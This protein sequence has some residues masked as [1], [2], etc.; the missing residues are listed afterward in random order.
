[1]DRCLAHAAAPCC[2]LR[3]DWARSA[4]HN[5]AIL[6]HSA[7]LHFGLSTD[8]QVAI[9]QLQLLPPLHA[10]PDLP[11]LALRV[12]GH[13]RGAHGIRDL[14]LEAR[15]RRPIGN[16]Y[17]KP[18][19]GGVRYNSFPRRLEL[20]VRMKVHCDSSSVRLPVEKS[21]PPWDFGGATLNP[22]GGNQRIP[23]SL[24]RANNCDARTRTSTIAASLRH[25]TGIAG[26]AGA[27]V[28]RWSFQVQE[29]ETSPPSEADGRLL[30]RIAER[31][32]R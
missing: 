28:M 12:L 23:A 9:A 24:S 27:S 3:C 14:N 21:N 10:K 30:K 18:G 15:C 16:F 29:C 1:V 17:W 8:T 4:D 11:Q 19:V 31:S 13:I 25:S 7:F 5:A 26:V 2:L 32:E 6:E 22:A 20:L